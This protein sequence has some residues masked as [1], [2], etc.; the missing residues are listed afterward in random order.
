M[1][2][3]YLAV[4]L[5]VLGSS[6]LLPVSAQTSESNT[7]NLP[8]TSPMG[9]WYWWTSYGLVAG[10]VV[11]LQ[12]TTHSQIPNAVDLHI[13]TPSAASAKW[14]CD[15]GPES[16]YYNF[17]AFGSSH[18]TAPRTGTYIV[19]L[20]NHNPYTVSGT[21]SVTTAGALIPFL[22]NGYGVARQEPVCKRSVLHC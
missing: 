3:S 12:W 22:G 1:R 6:I 19:I 10:Q 2:V 5:L 13:T 20:V 21:L 4:V 14:F 17:G 7:F 9:C 8:G 11:A 18:W 16:D 15:V